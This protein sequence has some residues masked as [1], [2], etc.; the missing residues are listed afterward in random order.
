MEFA[1]LPHGGGML[2]ADIVSMQ[3]D[4]P[5]RQDI[6]K[7][8]LVIDDEYSIREM[9]K[10]V[11]EVEGY[12]VLTAKDGGDGMEILK[13]GKRPCLIL[14]DIMMPKLNGTDFLTQLKN[15]P[16]LS[17]IPVVV[18]SASCDQA[19]LIADCPRIH[20]PVHLDTLLQTIKRYGT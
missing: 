5:S 16:E 9:L 12:E 15:E 18:L 3:R 10:S 20:K 13:E 17:P 7:L 1:E 8:I 4:N 19:E 6:R 2:F 14:L 11:L